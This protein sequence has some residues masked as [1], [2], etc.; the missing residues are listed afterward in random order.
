MPMTSS[1]SRRQW[2]KTGAALATGLA[3]GSR[4]FLIEQD[5]QY[6]RDPFD[7]LATSMANLKALGFA[8]W[9]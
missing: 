5:D 9:F 1:L 8:D 2:L 6:G 7:C 3:C 4:Y